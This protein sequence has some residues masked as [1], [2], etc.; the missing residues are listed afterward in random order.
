MG[1]GVCALDLSVVS[2]VVQ[3]GEGSHVCKISDT[4]SKMFFPGSVVIV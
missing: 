3:S 1:L 2:G 4:L